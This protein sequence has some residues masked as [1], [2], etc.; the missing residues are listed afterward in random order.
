[1]ACIS[2]G[3]RRQTTRALDRMLQAERKVREVPADIDLY[4][5][6]GLNLGVEQRTSA[7]AR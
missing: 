5:A 7:G 4:A 1:M 3:S 6:A 2:C